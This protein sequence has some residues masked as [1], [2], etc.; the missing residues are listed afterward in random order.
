MLTYKGT[1]SLLSKNSWTKSSNP[2]FQLGN[3]VY[4]PGHCS[5]TKSPDGKEDW[6]VYHAYNDNNKSSYQNWLRYIR[7]QS[8][9]WNGNVPVFGSPVAT[10][11]YIN[12][13][14]GSK[15]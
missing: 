11:V 6:I 4:G 7:M 12:V 15:P 13:P 14:S 1:G 10:N 3:G 8:F 5:F 9:T 2:L